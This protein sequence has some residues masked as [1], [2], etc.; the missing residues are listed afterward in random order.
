MEAGRTLRS[1]LCQYRKE[2]VVGVE[3]EGWRTVVSFGRWHNSLLI[4]YIL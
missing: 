4:T 3:G 1:L 2:M